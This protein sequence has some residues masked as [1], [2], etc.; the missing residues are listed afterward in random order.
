M[1]AKQL[2]DFVA[3]SNRIERI[4]RAPTNRE[5]EATCDFLALETITVNAMA[6]LVWVYAPGASLR[7]R[8]GMDVRVGDHCPPPGGPG[9]GYS[10]EN[11][12]RGAR[13]ANP[14]ATHVKY[15]TLHPFEDGNGRSGRAL[16]AW[17]MQ[18]RGDPMLK[19]GFLHAWYYQSLSASRKGV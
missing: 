5:V 15:E 19:L 3:E 6:D 11:I 2:L 18:Q 4:A 7:L 1:N 17:Q 8:K 10:L 13:G 12:L 14:F 16:W 9:I